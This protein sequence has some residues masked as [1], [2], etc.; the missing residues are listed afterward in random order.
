MIVGWT[1]RYFLPSRRDIDLSNGNTYVF[2]IPMAAGILMDAV[3]QLP[4]LQFCNFTTAQQSFSAPDHPSVLTPSSP[5][6]NGC[7][8]NDVVVSELELLVV[9]LAALVVAFVFT[10][11]FHSRRGRTNRQISKSDKNHS[12]LFSF[13]IHT[14]YWGSALIVHT[15]CWY[16]TFQAA[17]FILQKA[18]TTGWGMSL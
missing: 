13:D 14:C 7:C 3:M 9:L 12:R 17:P 2:V 18:Y 10:I 8:W 6:D 4:M 16:L 1:V 11:A 15:I 5:N